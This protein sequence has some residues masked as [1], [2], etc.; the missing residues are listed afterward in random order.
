MTQLFRF[1]ADYYP[2]QWDESRWATDAALMQAA[3]FNVVRLA[4]FAW[5]RLEPREGGYDFGWLDRA[6]G[7]L[8]AHGI[9]VVLG[10]PTASPPPWIMAQD[11]ELFLTDADGRRRTYGL[12]R[13]YCPS[14]PLYRRH[15]ERIVTAMARHFAD[16]PAVIG[17]QIDNEFGDRCYCDT[18]RAGFQDWLAQRYQTIDNLNARWGTTFWS[19]TYSDW[20]QVPV[21]LA[22]AMPDAPVHNPGLALDYRRFMSDTYCAFQQVQVDILRRQCPG[23]LIT[24][25][26][27]GFGYGKLDYFD[28]A[29]DLDIV[30]WDLYPR[31]QWDMT[32]EVDPARAA[33]SGDAMRGLKKRS[34]WVMEQQS[35]GGGWDMIAVTPK[36]GELRLWTYQ[37]IAH[38]ADAI[39]YFRWRTARYGTEQHWQGI[40]EHHGVPGR[41][42]AEVAQVGQELRAIGDILVG[43]EL[44][45]KA[46][47]LHSYDT[48]FAFQG[49]PSHPCFTYEGH[50]LDVYRGFH[51]SNIA[52][53]VVSDTDSLAGYRLVVVPA[54]YILTEGTVANLERFAADGGT[55][56]FTVRTGVKDACNAVVDLK[57]PGLA[58]RMCGSEV[59]ECVS[60]A[61]GQGNEV[62]FDLPEL[63][64]AFPTHALAEVLEPK[65]AQVIA[66]HTADFYAGTPA[67]T[68]NRFGKGTVVYLGVLV[69][70]A[71]YESLARW[72]S[73]LAGI[74]P[75]LEVPAGVE[76]V[77]RWQGEQRI[78][79]VL[80][81]TSEVQTLAIETARCDALT[82][83]QVHGTVELPPSGVLVL[84]G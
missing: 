19:H 59:A 76:T 10:T 80:N 27:M 79:L 56:V 12:R 41:R 78:L 64:S 65:G 38:G 16:N 63:A 5:A 39:L 2:E 71:C 33:L 58:A 23:Q 70:G 3:G 51:R 21:P 75:T 45:P 28:L 9:D 17:W 8:A 22:S 44:R 60:M 18:C 72:L 20:S 25:N 55:V 53:D 46:A 73:G 40:L 43:S 34:Y 52:L 15:S 67:A 26:L 37:S 77:E 11:P 29:A 66:H 50:L 62:Q 1:G 81:H 84:A 31:H 14:H 36:P 30:S 24:H 61:P 48:R 4:E 32:A 49:Q 54:M 74:R 7:I 68:L 69:D 35:G 47:I 83:R 82:G 57:L 42:Y 6:I 13:E